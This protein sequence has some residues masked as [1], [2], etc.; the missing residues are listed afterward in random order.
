MTGNQLPKRAVRPPE[1]A[2]KP[3]WRTTAIAFAAAALVAFGATDA[4]A[5]ALGRITVQSALGEP[6]R[7]EIDIPQIS[8]D[9]AATLST[10]LAGPDAFRAAGAELSPALAGAQFSLQRRPSGSYYLRL[11]SDRAVNDPFIDLILEASWATGRVTRDYTMLF[12]PPS[13]RQQPVAPMAAQVTPPTAVTAPPAVAP[14]RQ[15]EAPAAVTPRAASP[16]V[17]TPQP[18]AERAAQPRQVAPAATGGETRQVT[19]RPGETAGRI[20]AAVKPAAISLDQMLLALLRGNPDAFVDGNVNRLRA[21]AVLDVPSAEQAGATPTAEAKQLVVA[22]SRDFNEFRRRLAEGLPAAGQ[23]TAPGR[24]ATGRVQADVAEKKSAAATP[25]KLTLSKGGVQGRREERIARERASQE[26][27]ARVAELNK[28]LADLNRLTGAAAAGSP[29]GGAT[30]QTPAG[31]PGGPAIAT[32]AA[33]ATP[34]VPAAAVPASAPVAAAAS[35][36]GAASATTNTPAIATPAQEAASAAATPASAAVQPPAAAP[37]S[38]AAPAKARAQAPAPAAEPSLID[39]LVDNPIVPVAAGG[40]LALLL[41]LGLYRIGQRRKKN[42][43]VD[44]SFLESRLQP[45]S[46]FGASGGQRIDTAEGPSITGSS[47]VY[48][49]SQLDAAGDVDPVAEADVYLAYG[50]DLQAEEILKEA[51]HTTPDRIA[52]H[53]KMLEIYAKRRDVKAFNQLAGEAHRLTH[54]AGPEWSHIATMGAELDPDNTLYR[55]GGA[56][57]GEMPAT[58]VAAAA[59]VAA[60]VVAD[61]GRNEAVQTHS[62]GLPDADTVALDLDFSLDD[63]SPGDTAAAPVKPIE[64]VAASMPEPSMPAPAAATQT[65]AASTAAPDTQSVALVAPSLPDLDL[66]FDLPPGFQTTAQSQATVAA[67]LATQADDLSDLDFDMP[68]LEEAQAHASPEAQPKDLMDFGLADLSLDLDVPAIPSADAAAP[69]A[70]QANTA[71]DVSDLDIPLLDA[72][73][74]DGDADGDPLDTKLALA[75]EFHA[76]GDTDGARSLAQEVV[77]DASGE[78][79]RR[80]QRFLEEIG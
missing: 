41:G 13:V 76:I 4:Q 45:D 65:A 12:D 75:E 47:L 15:A 52:V 28:N 54:G 6:L 53:A 30:G 40:I 1:L 73:G 71:T 77:A 9:E 27:A 42:G 46:F 31:A 10:R 34:P 32:G 59:T 5:L 67:D 64:P 38:A 8:A 39:G 68:S 3:Q 55:P 22:Q 24:Q 62:L 60:V 61:R 23:V 51:L 20:A 80:A 35:P 44:S 58:A 16:A 26:A 74:I 19:V 78:L 50:R 14:A 7:A 25:D 18:R 66:D 63:L 37:A 79:K 2:R 36:A 49:P 17:R 72:D 56:P 48:S 57:A 33:A 11:S 21:G 43:G 29:Q 70:P 69:V